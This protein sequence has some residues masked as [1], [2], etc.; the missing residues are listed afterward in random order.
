MQGY[1]ERWEN[2]G[3]WGGVGVQGCLGKDGDFWDAGVLCWYAVVRRLRCFGGLGGMGGWGDSGV[4]GGSGRM[5]SFR[6]QGR[7][8]GCGML[9]DMG[10]L[11]T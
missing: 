1:L 8:W 3:W 4:Q 7:F 5:Q 10:I 9:G 2:R 11:G 6:A